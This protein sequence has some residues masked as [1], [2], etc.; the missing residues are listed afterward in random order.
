MKKLDSTMELLE[1]NN[2]PF[3]IIGI[4]GSEPFYFHAGQMHRQLNLDFKRVQDFEFYDED[5]NKF[6]SLP[7]CLYP[8]PENGLLFLLISNRKPLLKGLDKPN[9]ILLI[10][11]RD[12]LMKSTELIKQIR[13]LMNIS[14]CKK[15]FYSED[16]QEEP[17]QEKIKSVQTIDLFGETSEKTNVYSRIKKKRKNIVKSLSFNAEVI[18]NLKEGLT[19]NLLRETSRK[20]PL[21]EEEKTNKVTQYEVLTLN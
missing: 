2:E 21:E 19:Y 8:D 13:T 7:T 6:F 10:I 14:W 17:I 9:I 11:G 4:S 1:V 20:S 18:A 12:S 15:F 16:E 5:N 3:T